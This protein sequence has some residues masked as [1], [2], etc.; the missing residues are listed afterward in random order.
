[1]PNFEDT[2]DVIPEVIPNP[3][4]HEPEMPP[5]MAD[6]DIEEFLREQEEMDRTQKPNDQPTLH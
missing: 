6:V 4:P 2:P 5:S 1:M 3:D